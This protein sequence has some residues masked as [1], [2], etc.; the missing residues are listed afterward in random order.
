[1]TLAPVKVGASRSQIEIENLG[2]LSNREVLI[3]DKVQHLP[4]PDGQDGQCLKQSKTILRH[5]GHL[6][7]VWSVRWNWQAGVPSVE[8]LQ[9]QPSPPSLLR[10]GSADHAKQPGAQAGFSAEHGF[11]FQDL[12]VSCLQ[13]FLRFFPMV[14]AAQQGPAKAGSVH[15]FEFALKIGLFHDPPGFPCF[16]NGFAG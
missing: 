9:A 16:W 11:S 14:I 13:D 3:E 15:P 6:F 8:Y 4:L 7:R 10:C 2:G 12:Q 1:M 5:A